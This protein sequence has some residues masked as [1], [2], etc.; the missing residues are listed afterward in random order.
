M[1]GCRVS[2][3]QDMYGLDGEEM[4]HADFKN[5]KYVMTLPKFADP[6]VYQEAVYDQAVET[7]KVCQKNLEITMNAYKYPPVTEGEN[8]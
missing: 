8:N 1:D 5:E 4:A 3:G 6:F 2:D 7:Q